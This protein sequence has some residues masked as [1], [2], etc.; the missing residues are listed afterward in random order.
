[1]TR[2]RTAF[3]F[4]AALAAGA[5]AA[6]AADSPPK[7]PSRATFTFSA[8]RMTFVDA[9]PHGESIGDTAIDRYVVREVSGEGRTGTA[10]NQCVLGR[11]GKRPVGLC[12]GVLALADGTLTVQGLSGDSRIT[13]FAV[14]GGT[15]RYAG[16]SG[17]VASQSKGRALTVVVEL[18]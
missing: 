3:A 13:H 6:S 8:Q 14:T 15:G 7:S 16:A 11:L 2:I 10:V 18:Q 4:A 17:A 5:G 1:M 12:H 9:R